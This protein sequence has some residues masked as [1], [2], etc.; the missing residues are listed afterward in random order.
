VFVPYLTGAARWPH[1]DVRLR[2]DSGVWSGIG[3]GYGRLRRRQVTVVAEGR[4]SAARQRSAGLWLP[5]ASGGVEPFPSSALAAVVP[6]GRA[7]GES[8]LCPADAAGAVG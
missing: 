3:A 4:G 1:A 5:T 2:V 7:V 8:V 6:L